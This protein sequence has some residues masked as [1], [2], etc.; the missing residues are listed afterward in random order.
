MVESE[1]RTRIENDELQAEM[2][3]LRASQISTTAKCKE[4]IISQ[5]DAESEVETLSREV[6]RLKVVQQEAEH[7]KTKARQAG[8]NIQKGGL[9]VS[10]DI[11]SQKE[12]EKCQVEKERR[13][14]DEEL[15]ELKSDL[16]SAIDDREEIEIESR[17]DKAMWRALE[18]HNHG[19]KAGLEAQLSNARSEICEIRGS[20][21]AQLSNARSEIR[22]SQSTER[23]AQEAILSQASMSF[24]RETV[25]EEMEAERQI[26]R[27]V[28]DMHDSDSKESQ[29]KLVAVETRLVDAEAN[30]K[31]EI[32]EME[33]AVIRRQDVMNSEI[34]EARSNA[35]TEAVK[36]EKMME[37][38]EQLQTD[39]KMK[40]I[41]RSINTE[42]TAK[43]LELEKELEDAKSQIEVAH[44]EG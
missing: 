12:S 23:I 41:G 29:N 32:I 30:A 4:A 3:D 24:P 14:M 40:A 16:K 43:N 1:R 15:L 18:T 10:A 42:T 26:L 8:E 44:T 25:K 2:T 6:D 9:S 37:R 33:V 5:M 31:H 39:V 17:K 28:M 36:A 38:L 27:C 21:Q 22:E 7:L 13:R 35:A 19:Q 20:E 34:A 11:D